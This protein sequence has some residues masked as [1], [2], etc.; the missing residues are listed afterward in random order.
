[1]QDARIRLDHHHF[2][3]VVQCEGHEIVVFGEGLG[4]QPADHFALIVGFKNEK[5]GEDA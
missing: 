1:M 3:A 5:E 2:Q 4:Y